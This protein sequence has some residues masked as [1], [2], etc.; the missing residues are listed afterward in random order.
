MTSPFTVS[1]M[2]G[3]PTWSSVTANDG[4]FTVLTVTGQTIEEEVGY[5]EGG[6]GEGGYDA[7]T[8]IIPGASIPNWTVYTLK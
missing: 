2:T 5:G 7:P 4:G 6:Y 1:S 3:Q 8:V